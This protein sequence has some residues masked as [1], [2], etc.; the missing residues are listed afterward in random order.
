MKANQSTTQEISIKVADGTALRVQGSRLTFATSGSN[1]PTCPGLRRQ[2]RMEIFGTV[3][4]DHFAK[5]TYTS[6]FGWE[7]AP[8]VTV[9]PPMETV[10]NHDRF[11]GAWSLPKLRD[12]LYATVDPVDLS[13]LTYF[14]MTPDDSESF[15]AGKAHVIA[16]WADARDKAFA[17]LGYFPVIP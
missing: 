16:L 6:D 13:G 1:A 15:Q 8:N 12:E 7:W 11:G 5:I 4:G 2:F 14:G 9:I 10:E 17:A 3:H